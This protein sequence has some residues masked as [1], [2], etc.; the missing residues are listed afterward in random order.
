MADSNRATGTQAGTPG[1]SVKDV[2]DEAKHTARDIG[3]EAADQAK[4]TVG[5]VREQARTSVEESKNQVAHQVEGLARALHRGSD[6]LRNEEMGRLAEQTDW[7]AGRIEELQHYLEDRS[8]SE[9]LQD[10]RGIARNQPGWFLGGM[11]ALGLMTA[12]FLRSSESHD[13]GYSSH[14]ASASEPYRER[15]TTAL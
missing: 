15:D 13:S 1:Q 4:S 9:L 12:R 3:H 8:T 5:Y 11:F 14:Y 2:A 7:I 6:E 10:V